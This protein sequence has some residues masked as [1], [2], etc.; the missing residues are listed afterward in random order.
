MTRTPLLGFTGVA[1]RGTLRAGVGIG[2][3]SLGCTTR[4]LREARLRLTGSRV[5][6]P[7]LSSPAELPGSTPRRIFLDRTAA[8]TTVSARVFDQFEELPFAGHPVIGAAALLHESVGSHD[9]CLWNFQM[10]A[11]TVAIATERSGSGYFGS[12]DQGPPDIVGVPHDRSWIA[13]AFGLAP[14]ACGTVWPVP[15]RLSCSI[16]VDSLGGPAGCM[17]ARKVPSTR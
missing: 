12:L 3:Y 10:Q 2:I 6:L 16:R 5:K 7:Q 11:R 9:K 14:T 4:W 1:A 13:P 17:F 15:A 8:P